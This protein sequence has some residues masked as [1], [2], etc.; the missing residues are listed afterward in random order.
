MTPARNLVRTLVLKTN[1][2][3]PFTRCNRWPYAGALYLFVRAL[4]TRPE[5]RSIYL[6]L[7]PQ[8]AWIPGLSDIDLTLVLQRGMSAEHEY[9]VLESF[10]KTCARLKRVFPM[11]GE[12]EILDEDEVPA[13]L[14]WTLPDPQ[15]PS[16]T[17]LHGEPN[18]HVASVHSPHWRRRA[19]NT[20]LVYVTLLPRCLAQRDSSLRRHDIQ[21]RVRKILRLL[22]PI[23]AE[24]GQPHL[25]IPA[26]GVD[27]A[28]LVAG[29]L[30]A[31]EA[32]VTHVT[33]PGLRHGAPAG[34]R[35]SV[36]TI[37][38]G[39]TV[40]TI[41]VLD[42]GLDREAIAPRLRSGWSDRGGPGGAPLVLPHCLL[43]HLVRHVEP[44]DHK[45]LLQAAEVV[46]GSH[47]L[48]DIAP[49]GRE[50]FAAHARD[51]I[52]HLP[53]FVRGAE[54]FLQ[55]L[56]VT[57]LNNQLNSLLAAIGFLRNGGTQP[58]SNRRDDRWRG[59]FPQYVTPFDEIQVLVREHRPQ[60]AHR[61]GFRLVRS[62]LRDAHDLMAP[63]LP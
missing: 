60:A 55:P 37:R 43:V 23:L 3:W 35:D 48:A 11:L 62:I 7:Q 2:Y 42:D 59:E 63:G 53:L 17:L 61:A 41:L 25:A 34:R 6:R 38:R 15:G 22:E 45:N 18:P 1:P 10:W 20:A 47:P 16:W 26:H 9:D 51:R 54:L 50:E 36:M 24:A 31:L 44:H 13:W 28:D 57:S 46:E 27:P 14:T 39:Q 33:P 52:L 29:V 5:I 4:R 58:Y 12:V 49:P 30:R 32:A 21:R 19:I 40:Q 56:S 8:R